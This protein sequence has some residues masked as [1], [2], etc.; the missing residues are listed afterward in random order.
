[1]DEQAIM[2]LVHVFFRDDDTFPIFDEMWPLLTHQEKMKVLDIIEALQKYPPPRGPILGPVPEPDTPWDPDRGPRQPNR[3][4][5]F[6]IPPPMPSSGRGDWARPITPSR[7]GWTPPVPGPQAPP[8]P[9]TPGGGPGKP[10]R[11]G[12]WRWPDLWQDDEG[13]WRFRNPEPPPEPGLPGS[14]PPRWDKEQQGQPLWAPVGPGTF[15][16]LSSSGGISTAPP[17]E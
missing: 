1:M 17:S 2:Y 3:R 13:W 7:G 10:G 8:G 15:Q 5:N 12:D 11:G 4:G 16:M 9:I 14:G 6:A